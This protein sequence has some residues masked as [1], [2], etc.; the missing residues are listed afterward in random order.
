[1]H[2]HHAYIQL[3]EHS[4]GGRFQAGRHYRLQ[5]SLFVSRSSRETYLTAHIVDLWVH[6]ASPSYLFQTAFASVAIPLQT[7]K[8]YDMAGSLGFISGTIV[9][10]FYPNFR[11]ILNNA[12]TLGLTSGRLFEGLSREMWNPFKVLS[13]RQLLVGGMVIFWAGRLGSFLVQVSVLDQKMYMGATF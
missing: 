12:K 13:G 2:H 3:F 11:L 8:F 10:S 5:V 7:D 4:R 1:M 9:S 6:S